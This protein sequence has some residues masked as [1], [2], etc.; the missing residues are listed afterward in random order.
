MENIA[1]HS[2][3]GPIHRRDELCAFIKC[4]A[5]FTVGFADPTCQPTSVYA[6]Y[7]NVKSPKKIYV[8]EEARHTVWRALQKSI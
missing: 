5:I 2:R 7:S 8:C 4:P 6:A 1:R 3:S